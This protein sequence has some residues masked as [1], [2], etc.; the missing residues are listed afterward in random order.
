MAQK[1]LDDIDRITG[2]ADIPYWKPLYVEPVRYF[3]RHG[4]TTYYG[5]ATM[6][7]IEAILKDT[8]EEFRR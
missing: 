8:Y 4:E 7:V 5:G 3:N 6:P 1:E 2:V